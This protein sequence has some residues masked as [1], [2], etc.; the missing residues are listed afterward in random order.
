MKLFPQLIAVCIIFILAA[1]SP[2]SPPPVT[3]TLA[4]TLPAAAPAAST[5]SSAATAAGDTLRINIG[6]YPETIDPQKASL[7]NEVA[8]L[9]LIYE[10]LTRLNE[11]LEIVPGS[12]ESWK[13]NADATQLTFQV[14]RGLKYSDGSLLNAKRFEY[15]ILRNIDPAT[16]G[17]Y[18]SITNP[19]KGA[20]EWSSA[21]PAT[22]SNED[23]DK[24]KAAVGI[25]AVDASGQEC[26]GYDQPDCL[27]LV[28]DLATPAP[29]F[30]K[31][32][33][34]W[35]TYPVKEE[36]VTRSGD[37]WQNDPTKQIG[38]GPMVLESIEQ[39]TRMR[40]KPNPNYYRGKARLR[41]EYT[42]VTDSSAAF[43]AYKNNQLDITAIA[44]EDLGAIQAD[45]LLNKQARIYPGGC[46]YGLYLHNQKPP[47][48]DPKVREAFAYSFDREGWVKDVLKGLGLPTLTWIPKGYPGYDASENRFK[49]DPA[50]TKDLLTA[51][52]YSIANGVLTK[53]GTT[54]PIS[55]TFADTPRDYARNAW[56]ASKWKNDLG[57]VAELKPVESTTFTALT[58]DVK[59][60]PQAFI[61][62]K[63]AD[64]PD[65]QNWLSA[66][67]KSDTT[68]AGRIGF[69]DGKFDDLVNRAD[70]ESKA[71]RRD[72]LYAQAQRE[73][74]GAVPGIMGWD[75]LNAYLVKPTVKG[76]IQTAQDAEWPGGIDP[77]SISLAAQ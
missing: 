62:D 26:T 42:Y 12:A 77:L 63:C 68:F 23:M 32:M 66:Y 52:G 43:E 8:T 30:H 14:R 75:S 74:V 56:I 4:P 13:Y 19:I 39:N 55:L 46:T 44:P 34:L 50:R 57:L 31:V 67:W 40:F 35:V 72:D 36:L 17:D 71:A 6:V 65:P 24:L 18:S 7:V 28:I 76:L 20:K 61:L 59:T 64:Y 16:A 1:C 5:P 3:P 25:H 69:W 41:I 58:K 48:D 21:D 2:A 60:A 15:A 27:T 9:K 37:A 38:N 45:A 47:F 49:Y 70:A 54:F 22:T 33:S 73:V 29:Y 10:G 51:A 11:K 53:G